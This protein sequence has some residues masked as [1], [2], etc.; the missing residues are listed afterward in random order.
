MVTSEDIDKINESLNE[1][2]SSFRSFNLNLRQLKG[3]DV[4]ESLIQNSNDY[5]EALYNRIKQLKEFYNRFSSEIDESVNSFLEKV[6]SIEEEDKKEVEAL[7]NDFKGCID[8]LEQKNEMNEQLLKINK[9]PI[10]IIRKNMQSRVD[11]E[12]MVKYPG[13][14]FYKEYMSDRRNTDG[15]IFLDIDNENDELIVKYMKDDESLE[16]DLKK[17]NTEKINKLIK[18]LS[19]FELPIKE[20]FVKEIG[21]NEDNKMMEAWRERKVT[22]VNDDNKDVVDKELN[23]LLKKRDSFKKIVLNN[24]FLKNL[25]YNNKH[26]TFS[27]KVSLHYPDIVKAYLKNDNHLNKQELEKYI[28]KESKSTFVDA[29]NEDFNALCINLDVE[30]KKLLTRLSDAPLFQS[31][32]NII[33][34]PQYDNKLK[35]WLDGEYR[36]KLL[37]RASRDGYSCESFHSHCDNKGPTLVVIRSTKGNIFGGYSDADWCIGSMCYS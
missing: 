15:D 7:K 18:D 17:M 34:N 2:S 27:F 23:N 24:Q 13:S 5:L 36:W 16:E 25:N 26:H 35:E 32:S 1:L 3:K 12:L 4:N 21:Y 6:K 22:F 29:L 14:Y 28:D 31:I 8:E 11:K 19:F 33:C 37:Y 30:D 10:F 20:D 9:E